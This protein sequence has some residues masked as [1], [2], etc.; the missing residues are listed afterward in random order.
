MVD[1]ESVLII[2]NGGRESALAWLLAK[3]KGVSRIFAAPGNPGTQQVGQNV[4]IAADDFERLIDFA[5]KERIDLV[6]TGSESQLGKG[7]VDLFEKN[8]ILIYG[9]NQR[10]A[11]LEVDKLYGK[12]IMA[13]AGIVTP[14]HW[15]FR[16]AD[17]AKAKVMED[18]KNTVVKHPSGD[19][20]GKGVH[21]CAT[22]EEALAEVDKMLQ[23]SDTVVIE[24]FAGEKG[25]I[26]EEASCMLI[27]S[28]MSYIPLVFSQDHKKEGEG[29]NGSNTGGMG[30][31]A[32]CEITRGYEKWVL[33]Q[34]VE[35]TLKSLNGQFYGTLYIAL[36]QNPGN[37][38]WPFQ[39]LEYNTRFGDPE[40]QPIA[41]LLDTP[42]LYEILKTS[43]QHEDLSN[44]KLNWYSGSAI[45]TVMANKGYPR[46]D[47]IYKAQLGKI[48]L[49]LDDTY[50]QNP[51]VTVFHA[52]TGTSEK[53]DL[54]IDGGRILNI[55]TRGTNIIEAH[56]R[57]L[58]AISK[59]KCDGLRYRRDIGYRD[60]ERYEARIGH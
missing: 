33:Q 17:A 48:I 42:N 16:D 30:A 18:P 20:G 56:E 26:F 41:T 13:K 54:I 34:I 6:L 37:D 24:Q 8:G 5:L 57:C 25:E 7:I 3:S 55:C 45:C 11:Q 38:E 28:G 51:W 10:M 23:I 27:C 9:P 29:D 12:E 39:V 44:F 21:P 22:Q 52:G 46:K 31:Y 49:G 14:L 19:M 4:S 1:G 58:E 59:I 47:E 43:A 50:F 2:G 60:I 32:P 36:I 40:I 53:G 35:P 15:T